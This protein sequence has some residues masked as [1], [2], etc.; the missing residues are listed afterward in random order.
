MVAFFPLCFWQENLIL[1]PQLPG[2]FF[3][4]VSDHL[5]NQKHENKEGLMGHSQKQSKFDRTT[6]DRGFLG[7]TTGGRPKKI[8]RVFD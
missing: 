4:G 2:I 3:Q 7:S 6:F 8:G 1:L 5:F